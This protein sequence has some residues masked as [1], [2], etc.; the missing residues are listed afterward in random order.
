MSEFENNLYNNLV[1][2]AKDSKS[3]KL[4]S[5]EVNEKYLFACE[6]TSKD[7]LFAKLEENGYVTR[8]SKCDSILA[9]TIKRIIDERLLS[10]LQDNGKFTID[11]KRDLTEDMLSKITLSDNKTSN[12]LF[13][14]SDNKVNCK[15]EI[16]NVTINNGNETHRLQVLEAKRLMATEK[17][18]KILD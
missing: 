3:G 12:K 6:Q 13:V 10:D 16:Y 4:G 9:R 1:S 17:A 15:F 7:R 2:L 11:A 14:L 8:T 5:S 18:K